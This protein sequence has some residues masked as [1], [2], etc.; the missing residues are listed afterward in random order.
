MSFYHPHGKLLKETNLK[1][2]RNMT[3]TCELLC[4]RKRLYTGSIQ[5]PRNCR[6]GWG[7]Q[8]TW[9]WEAISWGKMQVTQAICLLFNYS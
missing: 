6:T 9:F 1:V 7:V 8:C 4:S 3:D 5:I 2:Y